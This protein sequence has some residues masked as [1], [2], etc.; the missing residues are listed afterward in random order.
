[1]DN[2]GNHK[3][4]YFTVQGL[5]ELREGDSGRT[6]ILLV[7]GHPRT[8][9]SPEPVK[10]GLALK[11]GSYQSSCAHLLEQV[12]KL[13]QAYRSFSSGEGQPVPSVRGH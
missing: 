13:A 1:M 3:V 9:V 2:P 12:L 7:N 5:S 10:D 4:D 8:G 11:N 6:W